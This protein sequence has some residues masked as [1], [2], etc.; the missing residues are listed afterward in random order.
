[1][2]DGLLLQPTRYV[3]TAHKSPMFL[4]ESETFKVVEKYIVDF[5]VACDLLDITDIT[6][7][8]CIMNPHITNNVEPWVHGDEYGV[9][10]SHAVILSEE[11]YS[12]L[13]LFANVNTMSRKYK[14]VVN[15]FSVKS[16]DLM[17]PNN[18]YPNT[19]ILLTSNGVFGLEKP[20]VGFNE[21]K[22]KRYIQ[23]SES[24]R[25]KHKKVDTKIPFLY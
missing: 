2:E 18:S 21:T 17:F 12:T 14:G 16:L 4:K 25:L 19:G 7:N 1:M 3:F 8:T 11:E 9:Y 20:N 6:E 5:E 22:H 23:A 24:F 10:T 15:G 13:M